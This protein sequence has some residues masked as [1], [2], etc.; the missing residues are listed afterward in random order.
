MDDEEDQFFID[1]L[2]ASGAMTAESGRD[3]VRRK[4]RFI[5]L[6]LPSIILADLVLV[7]SDYLMAELERRFAPILFGNSFAVYLV[8]KMFLLSFLAI[9]FLLFT[10]NIKYTVRLY[11]IIALVGMPFLFTFLMSQVDTYYS[12]S[13][14]AES[15]ELLTVLVIS[16]Y[17][18]TV[19]VTI[20][21]YDDFYA[22]FI[23]DKSNILGR[24]NSMRD[25]NNPEALT[26]LLDSFLNH[27]TSERVVETTNA[28]PDETEP[29]DRKSKS[30]ARRYFIL[31]YAALSI[32]LNETLVFAG[33]EASQRDEPPVQQR[34]N[35][36]MLGFLVLLVYDLSSNLDQMLLRFLLQ[37][38]CLCRYVSQYGLNNLFTFNWFYRL[39]VPFLLRL[40]FFLKC[41]VF[42]VH[43]LF[44]YEYHFNLNKRLISESQPENFSLASF[45][46]SALKQFKS[47]A[48]QLI[49]EHNKDLTAAVQQ[50]TEQLDIGS[51][52]DYFVLKYNSY[53]SGNN[54]WF[55]LPSNL[56]KLDH[57]AKMYEEAD[58]LTTATL[59]D[60]FYLYLR[61]LILNLSQ[62]LISIAATTSILSLQFYWCGKL[63]SRITTPQER[64]NSGGGQRG[65][66]NQRHR[67]RA[68]VNPP[69]H[70]GDDQ[71]N[72]QFNQNDLLNVGDVAAILFFLLSIQSGLS[73]LNGH[74]RIE[75]FFKNYT[76]LF[77][78][79]LHYFHTTLDA[80]LMSLSASS[81]PNWKSKKHLRVL[82]VCMA[83]FGLPFL[84]VYLLWS[85]FTTSTW[86]LAATAFN[87]ELVVKTSVTILIYTL[88]MVDSKRI[89]NAC[90]KL[91]KKT[92]STSSQT[93][94]A[95]SSSA[96]RIDEL[97][98]NLDDFIYVVKAFGHV[99]EFLVALFLF[100]NGAYI[101]LFES[102]GAVRAIMMSVHAYF[103][104]WCQ[105]KRGWS[106]FKKRRTAIAKLKRLIILN[107]D[108]FRQFKLKQLLKPASSSSPNASMSGGGGEETLE[109]QDEE[110]LERDYEAHTHE[111]CAICYCE[112]NAHETRIT[113][114]NHFFHSICLRKWLYLQDTC[115]MCHQL[116]YATPKTSTSAT[117]TSPQRQQ[118]Q[119]VNLPPPLDAGGQ[120]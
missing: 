92:P 109:Q 54:N 46:Y 63:V 22:N 94:S 35:I 55:Q 118:P 10:L 108:T 45:I 103:H 56:T 26:T 4:L 90:E 79:I 86:L 16:V 70:P 99:T 100:F 107:M 40:Y 31:A 13:S 111:L 32:A 44:F 84:I 7:N 51:P 91:L 25:P 117:Q 67:R 89:T 75:K 2:A 116:V 12:N 98:D 58:H 110:Q 78:A 93:S 114:C 113:N 119:P 57:V 49:D 6:R 41:I 18:L 115:P 72:Q 65:N 38:R 36:M 52:W 66:V 30:R 102:Y 64:D 20:A 120:N 34:L 27:E 106:A 50:R 62:T 74:I 61:V 97:S 53:G 43:F 69:A 47:P 23:F 112:L 87:I 80:Q 17:S 96:E 59:H 5:C 77:I 104:I 14:L 73:S 39:R 8:S 81:K 42:S 24:Y 76:L 11:K 37:L 28:T 85:R 21:L 83:L 29:V 82:S 19:P 1:E 105:A 3:D 95:S 88:F 68:P 101:L 9:C 60:V 71:Q 15:R 48:G 33:D